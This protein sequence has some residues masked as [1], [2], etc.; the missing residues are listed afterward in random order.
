MK[1]ARD[2]PAVV[3]SLAAF[4]RRV[5]VMTAMPTRTQTHT[6]LLSGSRL[7]PLSFYDYECH[8]QFLLPV[9]V[10]HCGLNLS[11]PELFFFSILAHSVYKM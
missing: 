11:A 6:V 5:I 10:N 2:V 4:F 9:A 1:E 7:N 8:K 3:L